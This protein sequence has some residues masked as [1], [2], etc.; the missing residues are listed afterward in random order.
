LLRDVENLF[1]TGTEEHSHASL[2]SADAIIKES[3]RII[4]KRNLKK[5]WQ[6]RKQKSEY[7]RDFKIKRPN[8]DNQGDKDIKKF[9]LN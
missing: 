7:A 1:V 2:S 3:K 6:I 4:K 5:A 9:I 8:E